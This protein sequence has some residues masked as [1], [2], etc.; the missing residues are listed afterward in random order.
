MSELFERIKRKPFVARIYHVMHPSYSTCGCCGLPW[1]VAKPH[2]IDMTEPTDES[3]G[4]GFFLFAN[5]VGS[6]NLLTKLRMPSL[7]YINFGFSMA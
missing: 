4:G 1:A 7:T 6:T 5:G 2:H 3:C